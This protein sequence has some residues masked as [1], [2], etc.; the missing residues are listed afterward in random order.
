MSTTDPTADSVPELDA[1][2]SRDL[3]DGA[4]IQMTAPD[5]DAVPKEAVTADEAAADRK[6][7]R[8]ER[9]ALLFKTPSFIIGMAILLFWIVVA[10]APGIFT[11]YDDQQTVPGVAARSQPSADAWF[12]TDSIGNDVF[13]RVMFG[14]RPIMIMAVLAAVLA[15][16]VGTLLGLVVGYFRGWVDEI[17]SRIIE[18][19]LSIPVILLAILVLTLFESTRTIIVLTI[20]VLFTPVV[21]RTVRAAVMAEGQLDYVTSAKLRGESSIFVMSREILPNVTGVAIVELT[22]RIGYAIFTVATLGFLGLSAGD[23]SA[24]NWGTDI[25]DQYKLIQAGQWWSTIFPALAIASLVI[26]VN[27]VAD[28]IERA[29][30]S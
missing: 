22:V 27:L 1:Q 5:E 19:F 17:I 8:R 2:G 7:V 24:A 4:D 16:V 20:A 9:M 21:A 3:A 25:S 12:G 10:I 13:A 6:Q 30:K 28:S 18:A 26:G 15:V 29:N 14:A 11:Q 23:Q